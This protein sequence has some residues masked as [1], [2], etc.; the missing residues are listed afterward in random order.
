VQQKV[1]DSRSMKICRLSQVCFT[2]RFPCMKIGP[3][4]SASLQMRT[5]VMCQGIRNVSQRLR[6]QEIQ[7]DNKRSQLHVECQA[8]AAAKS[9]GPQVI[10]N[11]GGQKF[12]T[13]TATL[14]N[15]PGS[16][17]EAMFSG[18]HAMQASEDGSYFID[19]DGTYFRHILNYLRDSSIPTQLSAHDMEEIAREA[20]FYGLEAL[21]KLVVGG[22]ITRDLSEEVFVM[23][24]EETELRIFF[25]SGAPE[26]TDELN[27]YKGLISVFQ[28]PGV[29]ESLR[30]TSDNDR[31][32]PN[33]RLKHW[34]KNM[35]KPVEHGCV[36]SLEKFQQRFEEKNANFMKILRPH[37]ETKPIFIAG[38]S[39]LQ[40]FLKGSWREKNDID[41]FVYA[42]TREEATQICEGI[43]QDVKKE[44]ETQYMKDKDLISRAAH[45]INLHLRRSAYETDCHIQII[46]RLYASPSEILFGFNA[47]CCCIGFYSRGVWA[48]PRCLQALRS[49]VNIVNPL[50]RLQ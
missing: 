33:V 6:D 23:R 32:H 50:H 29:L 9:I 3:T 44:Y 26:V 20:V 39:V 14:C 16:M 5:R 13:T 48:S 46:L 7:V 1:C 8:L 2:A 38:G 34:P 40:A 35:P 45:V 24:R 47:D 22:L 36:A 42:K 30:H 21:H 43:W 4:A 18:R 31:K 19:R 49:R 41:V 37:L 12:H 15:V 25:R 17:L 28:T 27:H 11:V 10:L